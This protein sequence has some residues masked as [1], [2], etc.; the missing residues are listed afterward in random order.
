MFSF[1]VMILKEFIMFLLDLLIEEE[2]NGVLRIFLG[3]KMK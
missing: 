3:E 1:G 2:N